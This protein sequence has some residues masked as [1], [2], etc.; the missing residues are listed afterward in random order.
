MVEIEID[1]QDPD[2]SDEP[3]EFYGEGQIIVTKDTS[4]LFY[5]GVLEYDGNSF[6]FKLPTG[7]QICLGFEKFVKEKM[8][9][10]NQFGE[11]PEAAEFIPR[12]AYTFAVDLIAAILK[13]HNFR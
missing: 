1:I 5:E 7:K 6:P 4:A 11:H 3:Y 8:K 2:G 13:D 12:A 9:K 10:Y